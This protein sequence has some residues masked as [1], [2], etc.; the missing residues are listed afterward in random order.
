MRA[1]PPQ[2][3][4]PDQF[5]VRGGRL[6]AGVDG[7]PRGLYDTPETNIMPRLGFAY[8]LDDRTVVRG[9]Y[10]MF[11]G[12]LGQRRGDVFQAGFNATT[13]LDVTRNNGI[14]FVETLSNPFQGGI[15]EPMGAA[16]GIETFLGQDITF[17]N[18]EPRSPRMQRWQ[19]GIQRELPG[20]WVAE[21][22][23]VGNHGSDLEIS[24]NVNALPLAHLSTGPVRDQATLDYLTEQ[25]PNPFFGLMRSTA[26][27]FLTGETVAR[28]Q[29]LRPYPQFGEVNT[30][31]NDGSSWYH[32]LQIDLQRRFDSGFTLGG[33]YTFSRFTERLDPLNEA[34]RAPSEFIGVHDVPHRVTLNGIWE[35]PFGEG[36]S[37]GAQAQRVVSTLIS[38]WQ[39]SGIYTYQS[40][41]PIQNWGNIIFNGNLE[42]IALSGSDRSTIR[43]S[44]RR[45]S[46]PRR[47]RSARRW[48]R[49]RTT[50]RGECR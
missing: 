11:Y 1:I 22:S 6:F 9:G 4:P 44:R 12:F 24:R 48:R 35:L 45:I 20:R 26:A 23:Y 14:T 30:T 17:F 40:G 36:R 5:N 28:E 2:E 46:I 18:P 39:V 32:A 16:Q 27:G 8:Q 38:G 37:F 29:L 31:T 50:T 19:V 21:I 15:Q 41:R 42:D 33:N 49:R 7:Q 13:N 34:D 3:I 10:G 47:R 25:I 43:S